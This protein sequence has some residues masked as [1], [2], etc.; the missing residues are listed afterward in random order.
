MS[1][2]N[3]QSARQ[4]RSNPVQGS[5]P[6]SST[7]LLK[8]IWK[9]IKPSSRKDPSEEEV[10]EA[11]ELLV[12][13]SRIAIEAGKQQKSMIEDAE[14]KARDKQRADDEKALEKVKA[15]NAKE[16]EDLKAAHKK[17]IED[18]KAAQSALSVGEE[19]D[20]GILSEAEFTEY[21]NHIA[22]GSEEFA[23]A[24]AIYAKASRRKT[25][26]RFVRLF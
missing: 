18:L 26:R 5:N 7:D 24:N 15:A 17:E 23:A 19:P 21:D 3:G 4:T 16:I 22:K 12:E 25:A 10:F 20:L 14:K 6:T 2:V 13:N 8:D 11:L 9:V 1:R